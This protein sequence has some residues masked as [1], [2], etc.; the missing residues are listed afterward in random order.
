MTLAAARQAVERERRECVAEREAFQSF[1]TAVARLDGGFDATVESA[2]ARDGRTT[3]TAA[4][5]LGVPAGQQ[6][7]AI[8][9]CGSVCD[10]YRRSV[11]TVDHVA[12]ETL[13]EHMAAELG[14]DLAR[15]VQTGPMTPDLQQALVDRT[16]IVVRARESFVE[17]L[18]RE[19]DSIDAVDGSCRRLRSRVE[20]ARSWERAA[21]GVPLGAA[22]EAWSELDRIGR[23]LD[24]AAADRQ[25]ALARHRRSLAVIDDDVT[26]YLYDCRPGLAAIA[27]LGRRVADGRR[28]ITDAVGRVE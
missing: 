3:A 26:S 14:A 5:P 8:G 15:R 28:A 24:E 19:S 1:R 9:A 12:G 23:R 22:F 6:V 2:M 27:S 10:A 25:A 7:G 11:L 16:D 18:G 4:R 13:T 17:L 21:A 20:R